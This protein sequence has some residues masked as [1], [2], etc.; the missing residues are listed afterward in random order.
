M[1]SR[2]AHARRT[3][4]RLLHTPPDGHMFMYLFMAQHH[5]RASALR[6]VR[7]HGGRCVEFSRRNLGGWRV[8]AFFPGHDNLSERARAV[9]LGIEGAA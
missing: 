3:A 7:Q 6:V 8:F 5:T 9:K 4:N 2:R 1:T